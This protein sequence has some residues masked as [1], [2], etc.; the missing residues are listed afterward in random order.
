MLGFFMSEGIVF[1]C[2]QVCCFLSYVFAGEDN[3]ELS[4]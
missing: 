2:M 1:R 3:L 4:W